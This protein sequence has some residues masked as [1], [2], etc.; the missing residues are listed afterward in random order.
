MRAVERAAAA[1][2]EGVRVVAAKVEGVRVAHL[3]V[4]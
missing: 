2:L 1:M 3:G 4:L